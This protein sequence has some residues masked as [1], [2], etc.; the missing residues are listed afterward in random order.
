MNPLTVSIFASEACGNNLKIF[1]LVTKDYEE[2][3]MTG[4]RVN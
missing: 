2:N 1:R 4:K 3:K